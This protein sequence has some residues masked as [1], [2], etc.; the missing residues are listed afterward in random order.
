MQERNFSL[1]FI[2]TLHIHVTAKSF[3]KLRAALSDTFSR[4]P[5]SDTSMGSTK[6]SI[7]IMIKYM[8]TS[9]KDYR[10][11]VTRVGNTLNQLHF[12]FLQPVCKLRHAIKTKLLHDGHLYNRIRNNLHKISRSFKKNNKYIIISLCV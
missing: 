11:G 7:R 1:G 5:F 10:R 9:K 4:S 8:D 2:K 3:A 6:T 12:C